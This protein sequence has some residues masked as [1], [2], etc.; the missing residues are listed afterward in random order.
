M[1]QLTFLW[2]LI[3]CSHLPFAQQIYSASHDTTKRLDQISKIDGGYV[4]AYSTKNGSSFTYLNFWNEN[5]DKII[6]HK[7]Y[8]NWSLSV[9]DENHIFLVYYNFSSTTSARV[10]IRQYDVSGNFLKTIKA[11]IFPDSHAVRTTPSIL[12]YNNSFILAHSLCK[13]NYNHPAVK[14]LLVEFDYDGNEKNRF[15]FNTSQTYETRKYSGENLG[16]QTIKV[17]TNGRINPKI[18]KYETHSVQKAVFNSSIAQHIGNGFFVSTNGTVLDLNSETYFQDDYAG[19]AFRQGLIKS[20]SDSV[21]TISWIEND[22]G[23][24]TLVRA[25]YNFYQSQLDTIHVASMTGTYEY[26]KGIELSDGKVIHFTGRLGTKTCNEFHV[27]LQNKSGEIVSETSYSMKKKKLAE[28]ETCDVLT[29]GTIQVII[30]E[31]N[32]DDS[33]DTC[34]AVWKFNAS[35]DLVNSSSA[36]KPK[37]INQP[38]K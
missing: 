2:L 19:L 18:N 3:L 34:Y 8:G 16:K 14:D 6:T 35:G 32:L 37:L 1:K 11:S 24:A 15:Y 27:L 7:I 31:V 5:L 17:I 9:P 4:S 10:D 12:I 21:F 28:L 26:L 13:P 22:Y 33:K 23:R 36:F 20:Q 29:D 25:V 30:S 38:E